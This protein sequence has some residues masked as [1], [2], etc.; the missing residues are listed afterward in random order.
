M[1]SVRLSGPR[2]SPAAAAAS[3]NLELLRVPPPSVAASR[4]R[5]FPGL[6]VR[7]ATGVSPKYTSIKPLGDR[8]L[9][10][11]KTSDDKIVGGILLPSSYISSVKSQNHKEEKLL[12]LE[13][14][15]V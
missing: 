7:A 11:I 12:Q 6:V 9:V 4:G 8:V 3:A 2:V 10:K 13:R 5:R 14:E 1:A 15:E